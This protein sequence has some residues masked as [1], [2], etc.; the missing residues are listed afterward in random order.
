MKAKIITVFILDLLFL[1]SSFCFFNIQIQVSPEELNE[2]VS[3]I[4]KMEKNPNTTLGELKKVHEIEFKYR[5]DSAYGFFG[6]GISVAIWM[7]L[8]DV[9]IFKMEYIPII[10]IFNGFKPLN[11]PPEF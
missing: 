2:V 6:F 10:Y 1:V 8:V 5:N 4:E 7:M 9:G 3:K 11:N